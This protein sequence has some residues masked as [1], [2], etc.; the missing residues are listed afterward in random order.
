MDP[1]TILDVWRKA[2]EHEEAELVIAADLI[3]WAEKNQGKQLT[4]RTKPENYRIRREYGM[5]HLEHDAY[6][7]ARY[8]QG[9]QRAPGSYIT[10]LIAH[11]ERNVRIPDPETI[12]KNVGYD[13][14]VQ[15]AN[16]RRIAIEQVSPAYRI[17]EAFTA[18]DA[19]LI[20][21]GQVFAYDNHTP[22]EYDLF[23]AAGYDKESRTESVKSLAASALRHSSPI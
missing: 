15:R 2:Q 21:L 16:A 9:Y 20:E 5:C 18:L 10:V 14:R 7:R 23:R 8:Q 6:W 17:A 22:D 3:T 13:S 4:E 11:Q 1:N 12:R 19:A